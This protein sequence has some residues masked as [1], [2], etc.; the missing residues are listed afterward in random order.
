[1]QNGG[2]SKAGL[3]GP[4]SAGRAQLDTTKVGRRCRA[5]QTFTRTSGA[6]FWRAY[7]QGSASI[8]ALAGG[9]IG[10]NRQVCPTIGGGSVKLRS[11]RAHFEALPPERR[12]PA[13]RVLRLQQ[14]H[15][16]SEIGAPKNGKNGGG[17]E[18]AA[19]LAFGARTA[20]VR[21]FISTRGQAARAPSSHLTDTR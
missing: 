13:R 17:N 14:K 11:R 15:A 19:T 4:G 3:T 10:A 1:M 6:M 18:A 20:F 5:A 9:E 16:G 21:A 12:P 8:A 2:E 7:P